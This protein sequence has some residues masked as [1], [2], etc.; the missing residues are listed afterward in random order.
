MICIK[1]KFETYKIDNVS[2]DSS[3]LEMMETIVP[4]GWFWRLSGLV[5][6]IQINNALHSAITR[7]S[8]AEHLNFCFGWDSAAG[9]ESLCQ[10]CDFSSHGSAFGRM[11]RYFSCAVSK[12]PA[13]RP[14]HSVSLPP[15]PMLVSISVLAAPVALRRW[16][17][18]LP[19]ALRQNRV[20]LPWLGWSNVFAHPGVIH[21]EFR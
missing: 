10:E 18:H 19:Q 21:L 17:Y 20:P 7:R 11:A 1:G 2:T 16:M 13:C 6:V 8:F 5:W 14:M 12:S 4:G 3:F 9:M 15:Y